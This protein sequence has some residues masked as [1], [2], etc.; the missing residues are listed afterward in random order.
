MLLKL[1][2]RGLL[3]VNSQQSVNRVKS[4]DLVYGRGPI[5]DHF[6]LNILGTSNESLYGLQMDEIIQLR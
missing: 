3:T 1:N 5:D 6:Y 2:N 4:S